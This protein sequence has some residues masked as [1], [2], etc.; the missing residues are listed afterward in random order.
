MPWEDL[1]WVTII[2]R[3]GTGAM[4]CIPDNLSDEGKDFLYQCFQ[5]DP[6]ERSTAQ[7]LEGHHFVI[8]RIKV[9]T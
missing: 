6:K 3:V 5:N 7:M 9:V 1:E 4:P 8:V 2:Y